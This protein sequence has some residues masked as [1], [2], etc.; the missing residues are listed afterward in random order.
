MFISEQGRRVKDLKKGFYA[1]LDGA[2]VKRTNGNGSRVSWHSW[3]HTFAT[4]LIHK[5]VDVATVKQLMGHSSVSTIIDRYL[6]TDE[7]KMRAAIK[8]LDVLD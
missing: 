3:R 2:K 4:S 1:L 7:K 8:R 6:D 5:G